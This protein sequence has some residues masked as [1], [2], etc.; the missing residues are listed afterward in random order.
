MPKP[1]HIFA[2]CTCCSKYDEIDSSDY[3][4]A[5]HTNCQ[6]LKYGRKSCTA[7]DI[8][9]GRIGPTKSMAPIPPNPSSWEKY[10][11]YIVKTFDYYTAYDQYGDDMFTDRTLTSLERTI[12]K[13]G[14]LYKIVD[15]VAITVNPCD[16]NTF[17]DWDVYIADEDISSPFFIKALIKAGEEITIPHIAKMQNQKI[18]RIKITVP[19]S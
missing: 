15:S 14:W 8:L 7:E 1:Q 16:L 2:C 17:P 6:T 18:D 3:N 13:Y 5:L 9:M 12:V 10:T 11:L 19:Q 4:S